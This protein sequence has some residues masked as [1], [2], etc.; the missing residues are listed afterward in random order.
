ML[1]H[2][3]TWVLPDYSQVLTNQHSRIGNTL[4]DSLKCSAVSQVY[5]KR[6]Q[7]LSPHS[8][9]NYDTQEMSNEWIFSSV[10]LV[11][12]QASFWQHSSNKNIFSINVFCHLGSRLHVLRM[13]KDTRVSSCVCTS[14]T[15]V[16]SRVS[17][18]NSQVNKKSSPWT[19][20]DTPVQIE[21]RQY[22]DA[23]TE[24]SANFTALR[25]EYEKDIISDEKWEA[26]L[27][28]LHVL[29]GWFTMDFFRET[30]KIRER[31]SA[32]S[33]ISKLQAARN[34]LNANDASLNEWG[35]AWCN[36]ATWILSRVELDGPLRW[37]KHIHFSH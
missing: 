10:T 5:K 32:C 20:L 15:I 19:I 34:L 24:G 3:E 33:K 12:S 28:R 2:M 14:V 16:G 4:F 27:L 23:H 13:F 26:P 25:I 21:I 30:I 37:L 8:S 17:F 18:L 29:W 11:C 22:E 35:Y 31:T 1:I 9:I 36:E 6:P 7:V